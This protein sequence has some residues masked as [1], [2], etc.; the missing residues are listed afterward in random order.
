M[1]ITK[2]LAI[3]SVLVAAFLLCGT[4]SA[5]LPICKACGKPI[6]GRY[7][8]AGGAYYHPEHFTCAICGKPISGDYVER[9]GKVFH[10][11]CY[12]ENF[13]L[14]CDLCGKVIKGKY[15]RDYWGHVYHASHKGKV[16]RCA[17]CSR[18]ISESLTGG[19]YKYAD[20]RYVCGICHK[21]AVLKHS[22]AVKLMR[23]V[24]ARLD[25]LGLHV[26]TGPIHLH[27]AGLEEIRGLAGSSSDDLRGYTDYSEESFLGFTMSRK[28]DVYILYGMPRESAIA[29]LAHELTHVW[30][31]VHGRLHNDPALAE[32]SCN[33]AAW[34]VLQGVNTPQSAYVIHTMMENR[35]ENYGEGFRRIK[36]FADEKGIAAWIR[37]LGAED[38]FPSGY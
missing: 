2:N 35:D 30:Q 26:D 7:M 12:E 5:D 32:G 21:T 29:T 15:I 37:T 14:R 25:R 16:P 18:F 38:A 10:T 19:G 20:G 17:H 22:Q 4:L 6:E 8:S 11:A 27:L 1:T 3:A 31:S 13:A 36:K 33:L 28:I 34:L 24:A 23:E 9:D